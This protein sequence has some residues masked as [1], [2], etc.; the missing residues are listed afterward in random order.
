MTGAES[1]KPSIR[2]TG[3]TDAWEQRKVGELLV[4]RMNR[5]NECRIS[6]YGIHRE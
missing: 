2:F 5:H 6:S 4:E 1:K 3:Y